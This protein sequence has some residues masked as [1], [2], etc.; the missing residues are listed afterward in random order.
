MGRA[1]CKCNV[2]GKVYHVIKPKPKA[3]TLQLLTSAGIGAGGVTAVMGIVTLICI[4]ANATNN[5]VKKK[6][7]NSAKQHNQRIQPLKAPLYMRQ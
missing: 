3:T 5:F 6:K 1:S 7:A 2:G 4:I